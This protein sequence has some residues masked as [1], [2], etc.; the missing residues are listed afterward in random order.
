MKKVLRVL[1]ELFNLAEIGRSFH[2]S[3]ELIFTLT[4]RDFNARFRGSFG[5]VFWSI[6]QPLVMMV[7]YTL[8]FSTFL[9]VR[10]QNSDSPYT[11][12]IFLLCGLLPW[13]AFSEGFGT[14]SG[15]IRSNGNLVK[16]VVFPLEVL[17]FNLALVSLI[18]QG[19]GFLLLLPLAWIINGQLYWTL[20]AVPLI[21]LFQL[22]L[23]TGLNLFWS[24]LSVYIPDL[25]QLTQLLLSLLMFL[26][27]IFYPKESIPQWAL[28]IINLNPITMIISLYRKAFLTGEMITL[29]ELLVC[30]IVCLMIFLLGRFWFMQTKKGFADIL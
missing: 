10:F 16:R 22:M 8:V 21:F 19:I 14:S 20:L 13:T 7:I 1:V 26:T 18:Q 2:I 15:L 6:I 12:A 5:G 24:S 3:R 17:P 4:K 25:K 11:F 29:M 23:Y 27:P 30:G 28:P 9:K